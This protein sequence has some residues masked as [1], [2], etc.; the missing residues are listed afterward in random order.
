MAPYDGD[1]FLN[2]SPLKPPPPIVEVPKFFDGCVS[3]DDAIRKMIAELT[4]NASIQIDGYDT[5]YRRLA[6]ALI[7]ILSI[8]GDFSP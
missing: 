1:G 5:M 7:L 2:P 8:H 4:Q 3:R 6:N